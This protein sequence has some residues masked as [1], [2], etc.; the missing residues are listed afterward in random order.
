M[1]HVRVSGLLCSTIGLVLANSG[2]VSGN[3]GRDTGFCGICAMRMCMGPR[4]GVWSRGSMY[5]RLDPYVGGFL[6]IEARDGKCIGGWGISIPVFWR[7]THFLGLN[8]FFSSVR[9]G[10]GGSW[11]LWVDWDPGELLWC[12]LGVIKTLASKDDPSKVGE[13]KLR[14]LVKEVGVL[15]KSVVSLLGTPVS[16]ALISCAKELSAVALH[17]RE[18]PA[19]AGTVVIFRRCAGMG[20]YENS[21]LAFSSQAI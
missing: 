18:R 16:W 2:I 3:T 1:D 9:L 8:N 7:G 19:V 12:I 11:F 5:G 21:L 20:C 10:G 15:L 13:F 17:S 14:L 4:G 6:T